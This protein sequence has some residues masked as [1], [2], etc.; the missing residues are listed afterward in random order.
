M[1]TEDLRILDVLTQEGATNRAADRLHLSQ[2]TISRALAR[3]ESELGC[4]LFDRP[5]RRLVLNEAGRLALK[6]ARRILDDEEALR[7]ALD[8]LSRRERT[9]RVGTVA[10]APLWR[11]TALVVER[12]PGQLLTSQFLE[13]DEVEVRLLH[14]DIDLGIGLG[15]TL[16]PGLRSIPFM[17]EN[18]S[19][20]LPLTHRLAGESS[21]T[22]EQLDGQTF[23]LFGGIGFWRNVSERTYPH[24]RFVIQED[25]SVFETLMRTSQLP[26]FTTDAP[27]YSVPL[28][29]R[30]IVP[31]EDESA[32]A[33][34]HLLV[35]E[36]SAREARRIFDRLCCEESN[37]AY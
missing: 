28:Q 2:P 37:V 12:F 34:F 24:S 8:D 6:Y 17:E 10:P 35:A 30:V 9:L 14:G 11:L 31:I 32:H 33:Y 13:S 1:N 20:V 15:P 4:H 16:R 27:S 21:L 29:G 5:G 19:I 25:R 36:S 3:V 23:L 26:F 7:S 22:P 18:L